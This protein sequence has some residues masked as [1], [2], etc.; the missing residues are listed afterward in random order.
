MLGL[1]RATKIKTS[2]PMIMKDDMLAAVSFF[3]HYK[4][5]DQL[6]ASFDDMQIVLKMMR[7]SKREFFLDYQPFATKHGPNLP[8]VEGLLKARED[9]GRSDI[10][11]IMSII[12]HKNE[13]LQ[14]GPPGVQTLVTKVMAMKKR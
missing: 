12:K 13:E 14:I 8:F 3:E 10:S 1:R 7:A 6:Q 4:A 9:F 11:E 5:I 2:T